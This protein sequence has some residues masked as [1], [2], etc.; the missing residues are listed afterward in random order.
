M[1]A[2]SRKK[3]KCCHQLHDRVTFAGMNN[4]QRVP[5]L[6]K[7][8]LGSIPRLN[9]VGG[10]LHRTKTSQ[11]S[12]LK[13]KAHKKNATQ[14]F[15]KTLRR[16]HRQ[17]HKTRKNMSSTKMHAHDSNVPSAM[18]ATA[19]PISSNLPGDYDT[20][21]PATPFDNNNDA[22]I[23]TA[24][25][26][27]SPVTTTMTIPLVKNPNYVHIA[28]RKPVTLTYCP[29]CAKHQVSTSTQTKATGTTWLCGGAG[30]IV[31]W[32]LALVPLV[33]KSMKETNHY[34]QN[35]RV[36]VGQVKP[37]QKKTPGMHATQ[38]HTLEER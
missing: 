33:A 6:F 4:P 1:R 8:D 26:E 27:A 25:P 23:V 15:T 10:V 11:N 7:I 21:S 16:L 38:T 18:M 22:L 32:P 9:C 28:S 17:L 2:G 31:F 20:A 36:K 24:L 37:F 12:S 5:V 30:V 29:K 3:E 19:Q 35:C 34:C 13:H 14:T